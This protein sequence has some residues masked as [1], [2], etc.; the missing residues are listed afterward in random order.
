MRRS[1]LMLAPLLAMA[2]PVQAATLVSDFQDGLQ[3]WTGLGGSVTH[4]AGG[5]L[6]QQDTQSTWMSVMAPAAFHGDLSVFLG[7]SLSFDA[8]N[9]NGV[10]ANLGAA[11]W[12]GRVTIA[13]PGGSASRD[14]AGTGAGQPAPGAGWLAY[15]ATLDPAA[16]TGNLSG[17]LAQVGSIAVTLEFND[18]ILEVAGFDNFRITSAVPEPSAAL[19]ACLGLGLLGLHRRR[20]R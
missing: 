8:R 4:A 14:L 2:L 13:G 17:A 19:M 12:F 16:W 11:P 15:A 7:G 9:L 5:Y 6:Q 1:T 20:A 3:G 10:A 18:D